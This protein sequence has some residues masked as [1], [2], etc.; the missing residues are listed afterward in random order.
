MQYRHIASIAWAGLWLIH[1]APAAAEKPSESIQLSYTAPVGCPDRSYVLR[2][3]DTLVEA[4]ANLDR[5]L[6]V[7]ARV[8]ALDDGEYALN[9]RWKSDR[10]TGQRSIDAESCQAATDAAAWLIA[11]AI[12]RPD[13]VAAPPEREDRSSN[14]LGYELGVDAA[15]AFGLLPGVGW[16]AHLRA[17]I[18]WSALHVNL[19]F[20]YFPAKQLER[21][22]ATVDLDFTEVGAE[23]CYL[24]TNVMGSRLGIGP[25]A[26]AALG[27]IAATS[28]NLRSPNSGDARVQMLAMGLHLRAR[29][30]GSLW[31][32]GEAALAWHQR[33][34][35]FVLSEAGP[36][37]QPRSVGL[38][39]ELGFVWVL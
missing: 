35:L 2:A 39:L 16:G 31:L 6:V 26:R 23:A 33:R 8:E 32:M 28:N 20:G 17:G 12:K 5:T 11:I 22:G 21:L 7:D 4:D 15:S 30:A 36:L 3:I 37:Y 24:V 27:R 19:S 13:Q 29:L 38:R 18:A 9:L 34:P 14:A 10:G 1:A 25:C